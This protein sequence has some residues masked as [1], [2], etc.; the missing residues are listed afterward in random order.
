MSILLNLFSVHPLTLLSVLAAVQFVFIVSHWEKYNTG[1][2]FLSWGYD[3]SQ[4]VCD[5]FPLGSFPSLSLSLLRVLRSSTCSPFFWATEL[6]ISIYSTDSILPTSASSLFT[7]L[8]CECATLPSPP[9]IQ[10]LVC[11]HLSFPCTTYISPI[12]ST[13]PANR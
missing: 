10:F 11:C 3:A 1:V 12:S 13:N 7:V 9:L 8:L 6:S 5:F 4:Y 2:L